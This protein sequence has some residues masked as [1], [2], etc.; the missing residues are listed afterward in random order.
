M[1]DETARAVSVLTVQPPSGQRN[2]VMT[3]FALDLV[4][5]GF[6]L[7]EIEKEV[8]AL[9]ATLMC[10]MPEPEIHQTVLVTAARQI[11]KRA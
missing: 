11:A 8:M 1:T 3:R 9:N 2:N 4:N 7:D 5:E 6:E 10:P